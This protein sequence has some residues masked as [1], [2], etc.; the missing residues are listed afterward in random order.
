MWWRHS[1]IG[2]GCN[3]HHHQQQADETAN[4]QPNST[5]AAPNFSVPPFMAH[6]PLNAELRQIVD[7]Q[8]ENINR[9]LFARRRIYRPCGWV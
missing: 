6:W 8:I 9:S 2:G 1:C 3:S 4:N 7:D 5:H